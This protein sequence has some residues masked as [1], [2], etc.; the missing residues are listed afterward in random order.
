MK[1]DKPK[2]VDEGFDL[3]GNLA[4]GLFDLGFNYVIVGPGSFN[5]NSDQTVV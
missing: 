5:F 4:L 1:P 2:A 3:G